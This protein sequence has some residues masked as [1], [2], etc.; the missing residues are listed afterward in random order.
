MANIKPMEAE[1]APTRRLVAIA[2]A[3]AAC[4]PSNEQDGQATSRDWAS[5][6]AD[7]IEPK[8]AE[9]GGRIVE[10]GDVVLLEFGSTVS[11]LRWALALRSAAEAAAIGVRI[12]IH[13]DDFVVQDDKLVGDGVDIA[14]GVHRLAQAGEV[15]VTAA[16]RD[17]VAN[18]LPLH[19]RDRGSAQL[20]DGRTTRIFSEVPSGRAQAT[21]ASQP[22]LNWSRRPTIAVLPFRTIGGGDGERYFGEGITE[23]IIAELSRSRSMYVIARNSTLRYRDATQDTRAIAAELEVRYILEGSVRRQVDR[24]RI[25]TDLIDATMNRTLWADRFDGANDDIFHFQDR[26]AASIVAAVEPRL[27]AVEV[28]RTRDRAPDSLDAYDCVLRALSMLYR[29]RAEP[30]AEAGRLLQRAVALDPHYARAHAYLAW[31]LNFWIGEGRSTDV[32][33]DIRRA[34]DASQRSIELDP[35]DA[36]ALAVAG[37][38][39][40]FMCKR[41]DEAAELLEQALALDPNSAFAWA[42]SALTLAYQ[43]RPDEALERLRNVWR[44][45]PFDPLNF[46]FWIVAGI[47]EFVAGRYAEAIGWLRKSRRANERFSPCLRM[48]AASLALSGDQVAAAQVGRELLA[49]DPGFRIKAF[50][51]WYPLRRDADLTRLAD[52]LRKAGLSD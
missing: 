29:F 4:P 8:A 14:V 41:L 20:P 15:L 16:V 7:I 40:A 28:E 50:V 47:A 32:P 23:D 26:I 5:L 3:D 24:L 31:W 38:I 37:H 48:L 46:Y 35:Q 6:R 9:H 39:Q 43:G 18:R 21:A 30:A 12:G 11:A 19:F 44:V 22:Y 36:F 10:Q 27:Q 42:L 45:T 1:S 25:T 34:V 13:V 49:I 17:Y 2:V 52:G 33:G 51:A